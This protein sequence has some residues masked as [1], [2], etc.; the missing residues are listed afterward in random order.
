MGRYRK[1]HERNVRR[2][3]EQEDWQVFKLPQVRCLLPIPS[4]IF[5]VRIIHT[6]SLQAELRHSF[7]KFLTL[8][9]RCL[10]N[11]GFAAGWW[12]L[13][14]LL[15][16]G[17]GGASTNDAPLLFPSGT[18]RGV[19][20]HTLPFSQAV[21]FDPGTARDKPEAGDRRAEPRRQRRRQRRLRVVRSV[22]EL[23]GAVHQHPGQPLG[24]GGRGGGPEHGPL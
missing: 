16:A 23:V 21:G 3:A 22:E 7:S 18:G 8:L 19:V 5:F 4:Y 13:R 6:P 15:A 1:P 11:R 9:C 14:F 24:G 20:G 12:P 2:Y 10:H 17:L